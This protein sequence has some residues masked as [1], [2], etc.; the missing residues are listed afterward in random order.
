MT[1]NQNGCQF[2]DRGFFTFVRRLLTPLNN[3]VRSLD[4]TEA[5]DSNRIVKGF[6]KAVRLAKF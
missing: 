3:G 1:D 2:G 4:D 5:G 6:G